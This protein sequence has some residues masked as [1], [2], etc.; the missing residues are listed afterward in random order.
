MI[1][2]LSK[3]AF[4]RTI[5]KE[6]DRTDRTGSPFSLILFEI[7]GADR[8]GLR[9]NAVTTALSTRLRP[10]DDIG[11]ISRNRLAVL[12]P[13]T[14]EPGARKVLNDIC[15]VV[16]CRAATASKGNILTYPTHWLEE[17]VQQENLATEASIESDVAKWAR[18]NNTLINSVGIHV[19]TA[20]P[21][22]KRAVDIV[23][24][25][26]GLIAL[27][28]LFV[29][30]SLYIKAVSPGPVFFRQKRV[31][32]LGRYFDCFK[33]RTMRHNS[34][35]AIHTSHFSTLMQADTPMQKLDAHDDRIIPHGML[36]RKT[37]LD[38]LPQLINVLRGEMSL[39]GPR[40]CIPY[41]A[42]QYKV[43]QRK[44]FES[45]PGLTGLWQVNGKNSTTFTEMMRYDVHY[46]RARSLL[47]DTAILLKTIPA[48]L[49]QARGN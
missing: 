18:L 25:L 22:W 29:V 47:M 5:S 14:P 45:L 43:W 12:L 27:S 13:D 49:R 35:E 16:G 11:R 17:Q 2:L 30:L 1:S 6:R 31:G 37:G 15:R 32:F 21:V 7:D 33:F 19:P 36:L 8:A 34:S 42:E 10:Y 39:I 4:L 46:T 38:E 20:I 23:G 9:M 41:E 26:I 24:A 48:I 28:P 44:R 3:S 40:P